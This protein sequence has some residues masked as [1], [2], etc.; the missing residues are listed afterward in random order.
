MVFN[1][2]A[3]DFKVPWNYFLCETVWCTPS[4]GS[5]S[6]FFSQ[7]FCFCSWERC[8]WRHQ[9]ERHSWLVE[10]LRILI[11]L[12]FGFFLHSEVI[13]ACCETTSSSCMGEK[14]VGEWLGVFFLKI[15]ST[16]FPHEHNPRKLLKNDVF[17]F[18][19][20][21]L[22]EYNSW[23]FTGSK[24]H[25]FIFHIE[26]KRRKRSPDDECF[27]MKNFKLSKQH[28]ALKFR[29]WILYLMVWKIL[30]SIFYDLK[31]LFEKWWKRCKKIIFDRQNRISE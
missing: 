1:L 25:G 16:I 3:E 4:R 5:L 11:V 27:L 9:N 21:W 15:L 30:Q 28:E 29:I 12:L 31:F 7:R 18:L 10:R 6:K 23:T 24:N 2:E 14:L 19:L 20:N 26:W 22:V 8:S 13:R 17:D